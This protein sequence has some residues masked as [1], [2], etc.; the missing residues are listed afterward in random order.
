MR[1]LQTKKTIGDHLY[2]ELTENYSGRFI[3]YCGWHYYEWSRIM[4]G[5]P[6]EK[7]VILQNIGMSLLRDFF[8]SSSLYFLGNVLTKLIG[9]LMLP[10]F[11][12]YLNTNE[13][14]YYDVANTYLN[15]VISFLFLDIYVSIMRFIYDQKETET[16]YRPIFNSF[17]IFTV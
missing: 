4:D 9:F 16:A 1:L 15:L 14:G 2:I 17:L 3:F 7:Y 8:K 12:E 11:T 10:I 13:Y 6:N 5:D